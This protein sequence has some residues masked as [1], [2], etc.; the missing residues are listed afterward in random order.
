MD[1][2]DRYLAESLMGGD[3]WLKPDEVAGLMRVDA[4][5]VTRWAATGRFPDTPS[6][7]PGVMKTL[8][9]REVRIRRSVVIGLLNGTLH[10]REVNTDGS[11]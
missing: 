10:A 4:K 9:G 6:G 3:A 11:D 2:S 1:Q 8:G 7:K 5:T